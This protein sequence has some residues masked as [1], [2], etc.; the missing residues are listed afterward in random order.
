MACTGFDFAEHTVAC[1]KTTCTIN[2]AL[3][4]VHILRWMLF[5]CSHIGGT[6]WY[7]S[8]HDFAQTPN[9][10]KLRCH[11]QQDAQSVRA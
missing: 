2:K 10:F 7:C 4:T 6:V 11:P 3:V 8:Y 1:Y 9:R 5:V